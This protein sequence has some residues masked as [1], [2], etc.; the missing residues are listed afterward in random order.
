MLDSL[1]NNEQLLGE[2]RKICQVNIFEKTPNLI[3][4][5]VTVEDYLPIQMMLTDITFNLDDETEK[6]IRQ[7]DTA[8]AYSTLVLDRFRDLRETP[9]AY[10]PTIKRFLRH[11]LAQ[12]DLTYKAIGLRH[13]CLVRELDQLNGLLRSRQEARPSNTPCIAPIS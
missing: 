5:L 11:R 13:D 12:I 7:Y 8:H 1:A 2:V 10:E 3:H 4:D 6:Y 9:I